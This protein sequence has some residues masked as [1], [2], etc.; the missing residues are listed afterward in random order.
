MTNSPDRSF[1]REL[2]AR[3]FAAREECG[4]KQLESSAAIGVSRS[5]IAQYESGIQ[6]IGVYDL[7]RLAE[8]YRKDLQDLIPIAQPPRDVREREYDLLRSA[9]AAVREVLERI[10]KEALARSGA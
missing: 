1:Y 8:F 9:P 6:R 2:G 4:R 10:K 7:A 5:A 3:L